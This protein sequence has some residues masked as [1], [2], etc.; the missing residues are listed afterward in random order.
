MKL[1]QRKKA[2]PLKMELVSRGIRMGE[3]AI[4]AKVHQTDLSKY[5]AG[6]RISAVA[7]VKIETAARK[8]FPDIELAA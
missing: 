6:Y 7:L 3:F 5:F 2:H 1:T 4:H 8:L